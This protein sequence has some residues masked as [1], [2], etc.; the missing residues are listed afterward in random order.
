MSLSDETKRSLLNPSTNTAGF[1]KIIYYKFPDDDS[2]DVTR[3]IGKNNEEF[4]N[5]VFE[6]IGSSDEVERIFSEKFKDKNFI[7]RT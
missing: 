3:L 2:L 6:S 7:K 1:M 4:D 5:S